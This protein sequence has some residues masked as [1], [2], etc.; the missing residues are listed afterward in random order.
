VFCR[1]TRFEIPLREASMSRLRTP[2][3][4]A[5]AAIAT[6]AALLG[7]VSLAGAFDREAG[8]SDVE[9]TLA[10]AGASLGW[11][12]ALPGAFGASPSIQKIEM[13]ASGRQE[14]K[15]P[16]LPNRPGGS[17]GPD[18]WTA[19]RPSVSAA[20]SSPVN[21]GHNINSEFGE[22][23]PSLSQGGKRLYFEQRMLAIGWPPSVILARE[24]LRF[25]VPP[26]R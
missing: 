2:L 17:G 18:I 15:R 3:P 24:P 21:L 5:F 20:W 22:T 8:V 16:Y 11:K 26:A 6:A 4:R 10:L 1:L 9:T 19:T 25:R 13:E 7:G 23:R 14:V 12:W